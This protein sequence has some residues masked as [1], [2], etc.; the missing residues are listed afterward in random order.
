MKYDLS[1]GIRPESVSPA[2]ESLAEL[3]V[4]VDFTIKN[5]VYCAV[6]IRQGL[7]SLGAINDA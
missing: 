2:Q 1:V 4:V 6:F 7:L 3:E 5:D